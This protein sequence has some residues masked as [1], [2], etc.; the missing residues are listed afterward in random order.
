MSGGRRLVWLGR[1]GMWLRFDRRRVVVWREAI[2]LA[3]LEGSAVG[4]EKTG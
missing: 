1:G 4:L 3:V 2:C